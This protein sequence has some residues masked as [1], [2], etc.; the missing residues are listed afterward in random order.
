MKFFVLCLLFDGHVFVVEL[1]ITFYVNLAFTIVRNFGVN[2]MSLFFSSS[3]SSFTSY[4]RAISQ[5]ELQIYFSYGKQE[6]HIVDYINLALITFS[7]LGNASNIFLGVT[8]FV[9]LSRYT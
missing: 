2:C 4:M 7:Q 5:L 1:R 6:R 3:R 9:V 8:F